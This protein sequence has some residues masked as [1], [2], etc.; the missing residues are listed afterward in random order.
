MT[1]KVFKEVSALP[2]LGALEPNAAYMVRVGAGFDF[3]IT[4][5]SGTPISLNTLQFAVVTVMP[6]TPSA[7]ILYLVQQ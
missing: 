5:A 7:D 4:N 1:F 6:E 3:Y 2:A